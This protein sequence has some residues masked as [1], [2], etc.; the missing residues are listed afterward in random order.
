MLV[1]VVLDTDVMVAAFR[2]AH[3]A[4]R[5]CLRLGLDRRM[6]LL[7]STPLLF[8]YEAVLTRPQHLAAS[9]ASA[10]EVAVVLDDLAASSD[11]VRLDFLW[12]PLL[13]DADDEMV[14]ET[15]VNGAAEILATFNLAD[16]A[17]VAAGFGIR[18]LRPAALVALVE[19]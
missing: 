18:A 16:L 14:L 5:R 8:E 10:E 9:G 17:Q 12:R 15:A 2:S 6:T 19:S 1:R 11:W 7:L 4:S 13:R 3:G